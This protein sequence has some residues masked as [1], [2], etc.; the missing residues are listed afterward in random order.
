[1]YIMAWQIY[2]MTYTYVYGVPGATPGRSGCVD[3]VVPA[4][5]GLDRIWT[6]KSQKMSQFSGTSRIGATS[7]R[8][9]YTLVQEKEN[10][11]RLAEDQD[12]SAKLFLNIGGDLSL[13]QACARVNQDGPIAGTYVDLTTV[14]YPRIGIVKISC[15]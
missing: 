6:R 3:T 11:Q 9:I 13:I 14:G 15:E 12:V 7:D 10:Q 5:W 1:M 4:V 2:E 8:N